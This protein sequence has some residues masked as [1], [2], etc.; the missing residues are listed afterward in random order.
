MVQGE[1]L[2]V[3]VENMNEADENVIKGNEELKE[4]K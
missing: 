1:K 4:V 2:G 3:I